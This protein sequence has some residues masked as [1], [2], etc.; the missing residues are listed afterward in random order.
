MP[1]LLIRHRVTDFATWARDFD[2]RGAIRWS[3]GCRGQRVF[4]NSADSNEV[5]VLLFLDDHI[6]AR[7]YS[8]SDEL[9]ESMKQAVIVD[10]P[11]IW[12]LEQI[13]DLSA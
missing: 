1:A 8:Q 3:H 12:I 7:L 6:R 2:E 9:R 11:D 13:D 4:R 5:I 10:E